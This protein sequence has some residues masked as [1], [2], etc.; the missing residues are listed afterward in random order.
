MARNGEPKK[1]HLK[2]FFGYAPGVGK[3]SAMLRAARR[4]KSRGIDVVI[5]C[6]NARGDQE[7]E[8]LIREFEAV[9]DLRLKKRVEE[10]GEFNLDGALERKPDLILV[11]ELAHVNPGGSRH[12][13]RYLDIEELL[14]AGID[15]YTTVNVQNIESLRDFTDVFTGGMAKER[16]PDTV[17]D[18]AD[19]VE[20]VDLDPRELLERLQEKGQG[21][22]F[23]LENLIALREIALR[24]YADRINVRARAPKP[25]ADEHILVCL[26]SSPSNGRIIRTAARM[27][28]AFC[29]AFTAL[30]VETPDA[31]FMSEENARQ[32]RAN[33]RL[34]EQLGAKV[35]TV[36]SDDVPFQIAEYARL[37]G[38]SKLVIGRSVAEKSRFWK[39][40]L[41]TEKL[42]ANAPDLDVYI[43]PDLL[44]E[45]APYPQRKG[46]IMDLLVFSVKDILKCIGILLGASCIGLFF[47][48]MGIDEANIITIYVLGVLLIAIATTN[49]IYSLLSSFISVMIFNFLFTDPKYTLL[50]Y[51]K[52]YPFTFVVMFLSAFITGSLVIRLKNHTKQS[53]K[54]AY[55]TRILF[56]TNQY[57]QQAKEREDILSVTAN[58]LMK[59]LRRD[60][61]IYDAEQGKLGKVYEFS[62]TDQPLNR[63]YTS[64]GER[65]VADWVLKNNKHAGAT[66]RM[67]AEAKS[68]YLS[69]R[70]NSNVYGVIGIIMDDGELDAFE[71][72]ILLSILGECALA[73][74]N[75]KNMQEKEEAAVLA[76]NEQ[77]RANLLRTISHDLRTPLT[78]ISGNAS[79]LLLMGDELDT[80][81]RKQL[82][83]DIYDDSMWLT[84]L[85]ENL[86]S[87]SR[88]EE[89]RLNLNI[90]EDLVDDVIEEAL[91][92]INKKSE[93][94]IIT[95]ESREEILLARMDARLIVQVIINIINN[96]VEYTPKGSH[97]HIVS[98]KRGNEAVISIADDG[99]GISDE[100][101]QKV[102]DMFYSGKKK[103]A[104][105]RRST[106]IGLFLCKSI[107][108]A[109]GG[110]ITVSD[111]EPHGAI[112]T[113]TLPAGEVKWNE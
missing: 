49:R 65:E 50:A 55:R 27:A 42:I 110:K 17:F 1:G 85:V 89:G 45:T 54:V 103:I 38:V 60:I 86:L 76:R 70:V 108:N 79:N 14:K 111:A 100:E 56:D 106:G 32:L 28:G 71:N 30:F 52:S 35:E 96:A 36:Y 102:F 72:S 109:H 22:D 47:Y 34:A 53:T 68:L 46:R 94:Y 43:I 90:T 15:V 2:I 9:P 10:P 19:Q 51:D 84:N 11:E 12:K 25:H 59:L 44:S 33:M 104:D 82:Y 29:G 98:E 61:V 18:Q 67:F 95:A 37:S 75:I 73:L 113:F 57:L 78:T 88:L 77:L 87:I 41:L 3:T 101:K 66:T 24:R 16:I 99:D 105:S 7:T 31:A 58:Q 20:I 80:A 107:I 8:N 69:I 13:M 23:T 93:D 64:D 6:A 92:H 40:P 39:K 62:R 81:T 112:F 63:I 5:G 91:K 26:S 48:D 97:I 74:E 21:N 4:A 83:S